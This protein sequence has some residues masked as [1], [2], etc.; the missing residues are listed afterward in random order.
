MRNEKNTFIRVGMLLFF[1]FQCINLSAQNPR[2]SSVERE[3]KDYLLTKLLL[4]NDDLK[5]NFIRLNDEL[6]FIIEPKVT[7]IYKYNLDV[8]AKKGIVSIKILDENG[9][10]VE[11]IEVNEV[12]KL[13]EIFSKE[14]QANKKYRLLIKGE[15]FKGKINLI[16]K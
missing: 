6:E 8:L 11:F 7:Q 9:S 3:S 2:I 5:A 12:K 4:N 16:W 13:D 15:K 1:L 14:L 10:I